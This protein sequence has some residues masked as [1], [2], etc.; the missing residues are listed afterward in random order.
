MRGPARR[1]LGRIEAEVARAR[2]N[3]EYATIRAPISGRIGA[4]RATEGALVV[5]TDF[6]NETTWHAVATEMRTPHS[7]FQANLHLIDDRGLAGLPIAEI[8]R[9]AA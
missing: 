6:S 2:L 8:A 9:C 7:V 1:V 3:L 5:R 4:A